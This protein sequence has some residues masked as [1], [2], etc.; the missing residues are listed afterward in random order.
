M[1][2]EVITS[3]D[4]GLIVSY[5]LKL[6][7]GPETLETLKSHRKEQILWAH[8]CCWVQPFGV[9]PDLATYFY[10]YNSAPWES[11]L[12]HDGDGVVGTPPDNT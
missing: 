12:K 3:P 10:Q 8:A 2:Y 4:P 1:L 6:M 5:D 9:A 7:D 11:Q